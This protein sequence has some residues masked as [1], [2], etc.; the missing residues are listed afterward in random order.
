MLKKKTEY[1]TVSA[2]TFEANNGTGI[3]FGVYGEQ[4][5]VTIES[6]KH[7]LVIL[8]N[9]KALSEQGIEVIYVKSFDTDDLANAKG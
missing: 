6:G 2:S 5:V 7:G 1:G 3:A 4:S 9:E 8:L